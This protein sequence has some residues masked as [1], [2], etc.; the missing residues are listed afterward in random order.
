[1]GL[2]VNAKPRPLY[3]QERPCTHCIGGRMALR[4]GPDR[5]GKSLPPPGFN[6]RTL[7]AL[8]KRYTD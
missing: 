7:Q 6:P 8:A 1:M 5:G 2:V 3:P 4:A